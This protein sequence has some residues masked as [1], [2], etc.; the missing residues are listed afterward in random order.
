MSHIN[1]LRKSIDARIVEAQNEITALQ[2]ARAALTNGKVAGAASAASA[3]M[4]PTSRRGRARTAASNGSGA[5]SSTA[6][7]DSARPA[8][9]ADTASEPPAAAQPR[10]Q[11][12]RKPAAAR[13]RVEVLLSGKLEAMLGESEAGLSAFTIARRANASRGQVLDLLRELERTGRVRRSGSDQ[14]SP[15]RLI[16]DEERIA[17][18]AAELERL[19]VR[20]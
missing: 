2:T 1:E 6:V 7:G 3:N 13:K 17:E 8:A 20:T 5:E 19:L 18:R 14:A 10:T 11:A 9:P 4:A 16:S 15:W 12:R